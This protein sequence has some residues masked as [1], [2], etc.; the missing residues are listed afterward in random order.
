MKCSFGP[1]IGYGGMGIMIFHAGEPYFVN[2]VSFPSSKNIEGLTGKLIVN[3]G[4]ITRYN[5]SFF[6]VLSVVDMKL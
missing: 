3:Y 2:E 5:G 1:S 4:I 6:L